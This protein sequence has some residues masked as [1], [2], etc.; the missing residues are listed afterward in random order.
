VGVGRQ[1]MRALQIAS[2]IAAQAPLAVR[3]SLV[4][5]RTAADHGPH[6]AVREF[7]AQQSR[8]MATEDAAEGVRSF[9]ERRQGRFV[10]A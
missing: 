5:S 6:A 2:T 4:S 3:A 7:N 10:G 8:L 1:K 9:I